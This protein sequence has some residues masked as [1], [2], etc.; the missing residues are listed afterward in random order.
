MAS[1]AIGSLFV[2]LG[3]DSAAFTAGVKHVQGVTGK[4]QKGFE[5]FGKAANSIGAKLS[6]VSAGIAAAG[7][8][9]AAM[10]K[11]T[12]DAAIQ[13]DRQSKLANTS[14]TD[15]Q[16]MAAG[17]KFAG[18]EQDK[19]AD[20]LKD[21]ND[22][23]GDFLQTGG[24]PMADFF[25]KVAPQVG[26]TAEQFK[27][28]SGPEA[29]QLYVDTMERA[30]L[31]QQEMTFYMEAMASDAT[32]LIPLLANGGK[33]M[34]AYGDAAQQSGAI[35]SDKLIA[36]SVA[37]NQKLT[38]LSDRLL[39]ARN[40]LAEALMPVINQF[41][42]V[43][44]SKGVPALQS[45]IGFVGQAI[46]WFGQ[47]PGPVQEAAGAIALALGV[48]GPIMLAIGAVSTAISVLIGA[49]GPIGLFILAASTLAAA[50]A[51][52]GDDIKA[53]FG[54]A[55]DWITAKYNSLQQGWAQLQTD[56]ANAVAA[57]V[58]TVKAKFDEL[59]TWFR[60]LP[61][62]MLEIGGQIVQGLI[63][64]IMAK[65]EELKA[66][67]YG[68]A[69]SLPQWARDALG[70]Q[71]PSRVFREIGQFV[72]QGL[73]LGIRDG[74][75]EVQGAMQSVTD[76]VTESGGLISGMESFRDV[77]QNVFTAVA[78]EGRKLGD[79]LREMASG[80]L[81]T[82]ANNLLGSAFDGLFGI[83]S[84]AN[85]T[86]DWRGGLTRVNERGGE[87]MNLPSG[88][89]IIPHDVS[90]RM[91]SGSGGGAVEVVV[92]MDE[93][94]GK[95]GAFVR[96]EA[97]GVAQAVVGAYDTQALPLRLKKVSADNRRIG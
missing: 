85:G 72:T 16:R 17:A 59:L 42:D 6:M 94:T 44:I 97:G 43:L 71:S 10:V 81:G 64:G 68:L 46:D 57:A 15:F 93:S 20:I 87:I 50:W 89:Q 25:E 80:W 35:M 79:V 13:I 12:A 47:L 83:G 22:R 82:A 53:T 14:A 73:G 52:W 95:L 26:V 18:I 74:V 7:L 40:Q 8:A 5:R 34:A 38:V 63:D 60:E 76:A 70:I 41:L 77:A 28:L 69:E 91:A 23:V 61:A 48:G 54:S 1:Q 37:F 2:A 3:L 4:L 31:S 19:L 62:K 39:G 33:A 24:G 66:K 86:R 65:W 45:F 96:R 84:N 55:I 30:G 90:K 29:L 88:T 11:Q 9:G 49:T 92:T 75:P 32:A 27:N 21:V 36:A 78:I 56:M 67:V 51:V 58:A